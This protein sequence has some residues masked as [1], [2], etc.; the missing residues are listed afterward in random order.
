MWRY[1][2]ELQESEKQRKAI[3]KEAKTNADSMLSDSNKK[4]E[5]TIR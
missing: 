5:Q 2:N 4:I 1:E 3:V